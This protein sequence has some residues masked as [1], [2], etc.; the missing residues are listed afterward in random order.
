MKKFVF[1]SLILVFIISA[2]VSAQTESEILITPTI[3][4]TVTYTSTPKITPLPTIP[5]LTPTFDVST[6]VTVTPAEKTECLASTNEKVVLEKDLTDDTTPELIT[7]EGSSILIYQLLK[8]EDNKYKSL[9]SIN[10]EGIYKMGF[11]IINDANKN[12][13][14]EILFSKSRCQFAGCSGEF[15]VIEWDGN[16]FKTILEE[17]N[18]GTFSDE[19]GV[20]DIDNDGLME[21]LWSGNTPFQGSWEWE[22]N[23]PWRI[24]TH[25]Y[26]WNGVTFVLSQIEYSTPD[27]RFQALQDGDRYVLENKYDKARSLYQDII[28]N[29]LGWWSFE[30]YSQQHDIALILGKNL[31]TPT[32]VAP[33]MSEY[34]QLASYAYYRIML[35]QLLQGQESEANQTYQTLQDTFGNDI[36]AKPYMEMT[37]EFLEAYQV[38]QSMYD[39]CAA[40]I[41]YAVENPEIL[42]PLGSDYH[43]WQSKIYKP[44]DVCPFR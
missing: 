44:E 41:Q 31:A 15:K 16:T 34:P 33:D 39:G 27:F 4:P 37:T 18:L 32:L 5:T 43:G 25:S 21:F 42:I 12:G 13:V 2:C 8:C 22:V 29:Q 36:Y 17:S 24:E 26:K 1:I 14:I 3:S 20:K 11:Q 6:I 23:G 40:A 28:S 9:F 38:N 19:I 30:R 35:L 10:S 7:Q